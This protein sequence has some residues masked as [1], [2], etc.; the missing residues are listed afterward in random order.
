MVVQSIVIASL[1]THSLLHLP[2]LDTSF[3]SSTAL[4]LHYRCYSLPTLPP[5]SSHLLPLK[6]FLHSLSCTMRNHASC[7]R[8]GTAVQIPCVATRKSRK[9]RGLIVNRSFGI[10]QQPHTL[11]LL[12]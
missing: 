3:H 1:P 4:S 12:V 6:Y 9:S 2:N 10:R 11:I 5:L 7:V 8:E